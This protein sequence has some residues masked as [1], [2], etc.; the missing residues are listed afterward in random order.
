MTGD[1]HRSFQARAQTLIAG[2]AGAHVAIARAMDDEIH[3]HDQGLDAGR[4]RA[5]QHRFHEPAILDHVELEDERLAHRW[6]DLLNPAAGRGGK[7]EGHARRL[8][9]PRRLHFAT[10]RVETGQPDRSERERQAHPP[11]QHLRFQPYL[12]YVTQHAL[13]EL[14]PLEVGHVAPHRG[15]FI[16]SAVDIIKQ[17]ARQPAPGEQPEILGTGRRHTATFLRITILNPSRNCAGSPAVD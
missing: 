14:Q 12:G 11:P 7:D 8:C 13:A 17:E 10:P 9:R 2:E 4:V 15:L 5:L 3:G 16:G 1:L 6:R